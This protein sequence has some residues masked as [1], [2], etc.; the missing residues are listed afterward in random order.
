MFRKKE[1][2]HGVY[3]TR[4]MARLVA[5]SFSQKEGIDHY[6]VFSPVVKHKTTQ[7]LLPI[8]SAFDLEL[9]QF[10][11]KTAFG[12]ENF[13]FWKGRSSMFAKK[14]LV[15]VEPRQWYKRFNAFIVSHDFMRNQYDNCVYSRKLL[16]DSFIY[17]M[18]YVDDML[19]AAKSKAEIDS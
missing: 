4:F 5:K 15:W 3:P 10:D 7:I 6:E 11:V 17:L 1:G 12:H 16:D 2:I 14:I 13:C 18:L 9:E 8:V 19:I